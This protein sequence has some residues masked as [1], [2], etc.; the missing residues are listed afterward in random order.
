[1]EN[2]LSSMGNTPS[3]PSS[4]CQGQDGRPHNVRVTGTSLCEPESPVPQTVPLGLCI[5]SGD[6]GGLRHQLSNGFH[7][8][9]L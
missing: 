9:C 4:L 8:V 7:G 2:G 6:C 1:M 3:C 5:P